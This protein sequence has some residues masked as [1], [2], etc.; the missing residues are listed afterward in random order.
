[1]RAASQLL[2]CNNKT[3]TRLVSNYSNKQNPQIRKEYKREALNHPIPHSANPPSWRY[4]AKDPAP[5][6]M[7]AASAL[8]SSLLLWYR[9]K[10]LKKTPLTPNTHRLFP[11]FQQVN[12]NVRNPGGSG[13]YWRREWSSFI[14]SRPR[15]RSAPQQQPHWNPGRPHHTRPACVSFLNRNPSPILPL[16]LPSTPNQHPPKIQK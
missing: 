12:V 8:G 15:C 3:T 7:C 14:G 2:Y 10:F 6:H 13:T 4:N 5:P 1:M 9:C 11:T 16:S